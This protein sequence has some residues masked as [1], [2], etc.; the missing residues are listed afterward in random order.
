[1]ERTVATR[2]VTLGI[3]INVA[4]IGV[5]IGGGLVGWWDNPSKAEW[6]EAGGTW[7][8]VFVTSASV[9]VAVRVFTAERQAEREAQRAQ[10]LRAERAA[11]DQASLVLVTGAPRTTRTEPGV[12]ER[13]T[14]AEYQVHNLSSRPALD[15]LIFHKYYV[16]TTQLTDRLNSQAIVRQ[17]FDLSFDVPD[18]GVTARHLVRTGLG[19]SFLMD[20]DRWF[21]GPDPSRPATKRI[22]PGWGLMQIASDFSQVEDLEF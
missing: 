10:E 7:A 4:G 2:A 6:I 5:A 3:L 17:S 21:R 16:G 12:T 18:D 8:G 11:Q 13:F 1:M 22:P 14:G 15:V 9:L 19:I 20:G